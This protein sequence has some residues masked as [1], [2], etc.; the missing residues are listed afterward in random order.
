MKWNG[1]DAGSVAAA[2]RQRGGSVA[3]AWRQ[4][5]GMFKKIVVT[6]LKKILVIIITRI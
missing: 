5:G 6:S 1:I 2:W 3:A 4:R